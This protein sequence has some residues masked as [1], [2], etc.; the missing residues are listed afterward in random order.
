[1]APEYHSKEYWDARYQNDDISC[2]DSENIGEYYEWY[3]SFQTVSSM[4]A[5]EITALKAANLENKCSVMVPGCG[6]SLLGEELMQ[7][8]ATAVVGIDYSSVIVEK[9][10]SRLQINLLT[11][12]EY[13]E[14]GFLGIQ[15]IYCFNHNYLCSYRGM[16]AT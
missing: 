15:M 16:Y 11:G 8:G 14:V 1:M 7:C 5:R 6:N 3:V 12:L 13:R 2:P 10:K 4:V 9:M